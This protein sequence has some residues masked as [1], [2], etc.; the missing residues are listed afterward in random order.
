M[1]GMLQVWT[2]L[3][4]PPLKGAEN[5]W[6]G[7]VLVHKIVNNIEAE[8]KRLR[9]PNRFFTT[10]GMN[11]WPNLLNVLLIR[12]RPVAPESDERLRAPAN[13]RHRVR[14]HPRQNRNSVPAPELCHLTQLVVTASRR[15]I[16]L[17]KAI[18]V[19]IGPEFSSNRIRFLTTKNGHYGWLKTG[20]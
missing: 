6:L 4:L 9:K 11:Q 20:F 15:V 17:I 2:R 14:M 3:E 5:C 12:F 8:N 16:N 7:S 13:G 18:S 10:K 19:I 1:Y